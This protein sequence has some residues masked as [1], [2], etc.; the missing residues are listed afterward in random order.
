MAPDETP[1]STTNTAGQGA[2]GQGSAGQ[3]ATG[4]GSAGQGATGQ[5]SAGQGA[6]GQGSAGQGATGQGSAAQGAT[7]E[8][9]AEIER[10]KAELEGCSD[11]MLR[12]QA[13]LENFRKRARRELDDE[14]LYANVPL[15]RD[16]LPALDNMQRAIAAIEKNAATA[17]MVEGIRMVAQGFEALLVRYHCKKIEAMGMPFDPAFHEA[18]AQQP[19]PELP[20]HTVMAVAV[21]GYVVH[22]RVLRPAQVVVSQ[23]S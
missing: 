11:R 16:L 15:L 22:D 13:E 23:A 17:P 7:A 8:A 6:T 19:A 5:G 10:L 4:Q 18:I 14:R 2:T 1:R 12:A 20:A 9:P 3:G 21:D